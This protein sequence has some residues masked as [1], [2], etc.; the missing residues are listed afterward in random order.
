MYAAS[1]SG[2]DEGEDD[3]SASG[4]GQVH[5]APPFWRMYETSSASAATAPKTPAPSA[6]PPTTSD[7]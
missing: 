6:Q 1:T 5:P 3:L 7:Q 2:P 4:I